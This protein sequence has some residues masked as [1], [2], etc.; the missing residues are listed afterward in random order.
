[1]RWNSILGK[2][3]V[4]DDCRAIGTLAQ[5][6]DLMLALPEHHRRN[7]H[8]QYAGELLL[9]AADQG[10]KYAVMDARAQLTRALMA[11]G[12]TSAAVQPKPATARRSRRLGTR[13]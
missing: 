4:L 2:P 6:R 8:W 12:L 5:A 10:E 3:I 13:L 11:E 9:K 7:A 1:M